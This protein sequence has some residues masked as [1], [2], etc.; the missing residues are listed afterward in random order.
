[1]Q[2]LH[3]GETFPK[4]TV[5][6]LGG[7]EMVLGAPGGGIRPPNGRGLQSGLRIGQ[8]YSG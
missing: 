3:A 7:G 6:Q 1:M 8:G 2:T 5:A 4:Q